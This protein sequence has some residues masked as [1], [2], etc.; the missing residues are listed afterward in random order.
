MEALQKEAALTLAQTQTKE[1]SE[2][3]YR[4]Y[5]GRQGKMTA[6]LRGLGQLPKEERP[7]V[8]QT[9]NQVKA[10]LE[11]AL[12]ERQN[13]LEQEEITRTLSA[14]GIDV[15]LPGRPQLFGKLHP[16]TVAMREIVDILVQMG[17]Q[18]YDAPEVET[19]E[20]NFGLLNFLPGH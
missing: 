4:D 16:T 19:D 5:L 7:L 9:A 15:T 14:E 18:V 8:G 12:E 13:A 11:S 17:F 2:A 10:A 3:W 1:A 6:I 20:M